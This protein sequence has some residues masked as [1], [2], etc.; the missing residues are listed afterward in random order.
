MS[1]TPS[2]SISL[3]ILVLPPADAATATVDLR[4]TGEALIG[5]WESAEGFNER[6]IEHILIGRLGGGGGVDSGVKAEN[7]K[8]EAERTTK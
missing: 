5:E 6:E 1:T 8:A 4:L 3:C 7:T 2:F